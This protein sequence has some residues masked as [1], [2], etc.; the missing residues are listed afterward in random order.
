M[1][2]RP[3]IST[4]LIT[5]NMLL[6][7]LL[8]PAFSFLFMKEITHLRDTQLERN[9]NTIRQSLT[10]SM[11][12]MVR[13]TALSANEAVAGYNFT[14]LQN[15]LAEVSLDDQEIK[16]CMIIDQHQMIV[17]HSDK[18]QIGS[19]LTRAADKRISTLLTSKFPPSI[20]SNMTSSKAELKAEIIWPD[21]EEADGVMTAAFP[22]YLSNALWG[23]IRCDHSTTTVNQQ[24]TQAKEEWAI[25]LHQ[26]K[27]YFI[28][29]L[30]FFLGAGFVIAILLTRSFVRSTQILH[31][32]VQQVAMGD[33]DMEIS[34]QG[35]VCE[36]FL[37]LI[38][39]FNSMTER[40]KDSQRKLEDYSRSLE[41]KVLE[42]TQALHETQQILVQQAHEAGLA[43]MAVG[44]LHNIGNAITPA[45][46][47]TTVLSNQLTASPLRHR[48]EQALTPLRDYLNGSRE[49]SPQERQ[50]F[51]TLLHH[52]PTSLIEEYDR[53]IRELKDIQDKHHHIETII[54]LQMRYAKVKEYTELVDISRLAQDAIKIIADAITKRHITLMLDIQETPL[55][56][57][58][59]SK[60]LQVMVNLIKNSY[61]AMDTTDVSTRE[62]TVFTGVCPS[63]P[64][65]V[66]F[67]VKDTGCGFTAEEKLQLFNYGYSTKQRGSGF[68]L[69]SCANTIIANHGIIEA[70]SAGPGKGAEFSILLPITAE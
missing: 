55:I 17:A 36:E 52:L 28:G 47:A 38:F 44:V 4:Y 13:S 33:L 9:I 22:I 23:I 6:L 21:K 26:A 31:T 51:A 1:W 16:S 70:T 12:S 43:E 10:T 65:W 67:S 3:S 11:T 15:L 49:L 54:K 46:V 39:S 56:R 45:K 41:D 32:G 2:K 35:V 25:Q 63:K 58:E 61:E 68:G 37:D 24:I 5:M 42:R 27:N 40:L 18:T 59:E 57:T 50:K 29:L 62:L 66:L 69:H 20:Q 7:G 30:V 53:T 19:A 64:D 60:I 34:I 8:F 48:L 14:F